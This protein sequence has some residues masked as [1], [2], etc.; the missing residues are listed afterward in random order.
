[1][2]DVIQIY[3]AS[4]AT[5]STRIEGSHAVCII[6]VPFLLIVKDLVCLADAFEFYV[7]RLSLIFRDLIRMML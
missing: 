7:G 5:T 6:E 1:L 3:P 2:E 4:H